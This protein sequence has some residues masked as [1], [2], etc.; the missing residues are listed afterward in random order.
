[1]LRRGRR[2]DKLH[3]PKLFSA[4]ATP[5]DVLWVALRALWFRIVEGVTIFAKHYKAVLVLLALTAGGLLVHGYHP[6]S[7]DAEIYLPGV[8]KILYPELFPAGQEFFGSHANLTLFPNLIAFSLR[9]LHLPL[10]VGLLLWH[11]LSIFLFLLACWELSARFVPNVR[12]RWAGVALVA[13]LLTLP[14]AGT[15][16]YIVDQYLN[17]RNLSAFA[18]MFAVTCVIAKKYLWAGLWLG[19]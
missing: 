5:R 9:V 7:E 17:P 19:F 1:M 16:L 2:T 6:Y 15:D 13:A 8:L 14:V 3:E 11:G 4:P 18:C 10:E 12:A